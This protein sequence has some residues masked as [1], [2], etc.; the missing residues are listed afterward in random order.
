MS[1]VSPEAELFQEM[2]D[3]VARR[4]QEVDVTRLVPTDRRTPGV[5]RIVLS[6]F[7]GVDGIPTIVR[8]TTVVLDTT[9]DGDETRGAPIVRD[10]TAAGVETYRMRVRWRDGHPST[11]DDDPKVELR[12]R[13]YRDEHAQADMAALQTLLQTVGF[14]PEP[15]L[16]V[17]GVASQTSN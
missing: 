9:A 10:T 15:E 8:E 7:T 2:Y 17:A 3:A 4:G 12:R 11:H 1:E 13:P 5:G 6:A 16:A 14:L